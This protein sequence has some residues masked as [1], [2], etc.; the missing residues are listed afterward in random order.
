MSDGYGSRGF[1]G[2][3]LIIPVEIAASILALLVGALGKFM[4]D[5]AMLKSKMRRLEDDHR[6]KLKY[7]EQGVDRMARVE[8]RLS[9]L[10]HSC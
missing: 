5:V 2:N 3:S 1:E 6:F 7:I 10:E 8:E 9:S 4:F